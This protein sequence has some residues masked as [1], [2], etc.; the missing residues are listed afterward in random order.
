VFED[1]ILIFNNNGG[2][3]GGGGGGGGL[4]DGPAGGGWLG[5]AS[6]A[7]EYSLNESAKTASLIWDYTDNSTSSFSMGDAKRLPNGNTQV[8]YSASGVI[9]EVTSSKDVVLT[10]SWN[11]QFG[12]ASRRESLY[13]PPP[14]YSYY[15]QK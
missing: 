14:E 9:K 12:Y 10:V 5:G 8:V 4:D 1:S 3:T 11:G 6:H 15:P 2:A 13:A 7:I